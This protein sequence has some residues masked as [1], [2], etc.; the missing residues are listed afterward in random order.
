MKNVYKIKITF[1]GLFFNLVQATGLEP[2][3]V[4]PLGPEPSASANSA[5]LAQNL[6]ILRG[7]RK[8]LLFK[9]LYHYKIKIWVN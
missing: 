6:K 2:A 1:I 4:T 9:N 8:W 7:L 5:M 3:W